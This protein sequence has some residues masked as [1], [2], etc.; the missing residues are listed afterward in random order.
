MQTA[1]DAGTAGSTDLT[2]IDPIRVERD[3]TYVRRRFWDKLR[4]NLHRVPFLDQAL[5]AFY[6]ATDPAT[7][8]KA[9][10]MLLAALA[11]FIMP[12]DVV[13]DW[14]I[15]AGFTDDA[16]VLAAAIQAVRMNMKPEHLE[17]ARATLEAERKKAEAA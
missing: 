7:P 4:A 14:L 13:P 2:V 10:A 1:T 8:M 11:Y 5:A 12:V 9:K 15:L 16:A 17:R 3:E 6:C